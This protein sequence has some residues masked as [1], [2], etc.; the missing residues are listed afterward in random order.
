M[1][2][3]TDMLQESGDTHTQFRGGVAPERQVRF[4]TDNHLKT[5]GCVFWKFYVL[6]HMLFAIAEFYSLMR[7]YLL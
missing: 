7:T 3:N 5:P 4:T 2:Q 6:M 1:S